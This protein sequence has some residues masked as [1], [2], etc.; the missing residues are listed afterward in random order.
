LQAEPAVTGG[1]AAPRALILAAGEGT[2][3]WPLTADRPKPMVEVAGRP[4]LEWIIGWLR[5]YGV[6]EIAINL[7]HRP[8]PLVEYFGDG[9]A[10]GVRLTYSPEDRLLG[11]AGAAK[12]LESFFGGDDF[13]VIY[14]DVLTDLPLDVFWAGHR[15]GGG[16]AT[17]AVTPVEDVTRVGV[18]ELGEAGTIRGFRE[19]PA[20]GETTSKLGNGGIYALSARVLARLEAGPADFGQH[21]FPALLDAGERLVAWPF[22]GYLLDIGDPARLRQA[23]EDVRRG[24]VRVYGRAEGPVPEAAAGAQAG[25]PP[26]C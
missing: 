12:R 8:E 1:E 21:V 26:P 2:R 6:Q 14:G 18:V 20:V 22:D 13:L 7:H 9:R 11:S 4:L 5:A 3:L 24:R 10:H 25:G 16:A 23:D 17:L 15:A 19:K